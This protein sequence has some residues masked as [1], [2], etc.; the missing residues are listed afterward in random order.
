MIG[1]K[2]TGVEEVVVAYQSE[3]GVAE[4]ERAHARGELPGRWPYG[5]DAIARPG[6]TVRYREVAPPSRVGRVLGHLVER[7]GISSPALGSAECSLLTWDEGTAARVIGRRRNRAHYSGVIWLT[8]RENPR[9]YPRLLRALS[10]CAGLWVLSRAQ[11]EPLQSVLGPECPPV[12]FIGFG[13]DTS[14]Y[15]P[16]P[17]PAKPLILT[18]GGDRDRDLGALFEALALIRKAAPDTEIVVQGKT[19]AAPPPGVTLVPALSHVA[20]RDLYRRMSLV[21][22]AT[23]PNLHVSGMTVALEAMATGRPCVITGSP[24]MADYVE[25]GTDGLV[26]KRNPQSLATAVLDLLNQPDDMRRMG[27]A[28][29]A[30]VRARHTQETMAAQLRALMGTA[31]DA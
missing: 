26:V 6:L 12:S 19:T 25:H 2:G 30:K 22:L 17:F 11:I 8:D 5:L 9:R 31:G 28:G 20:L 29:L 15:T 23:R 10:R 16:A 1:W 18:A 14:F 27:L 7:A 3:K 21:V 24:G 13:I 4:W